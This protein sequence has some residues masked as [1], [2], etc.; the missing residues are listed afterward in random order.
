MSDTVS[1][2][3]L[4]REL[5][6]NLLRAYKTEEELW[7]QRS[8][9]LWLSLGDSNTAYFHAV[10]RGRRA[11]NKLSVIETESGVPVYEEEKIASVITQY[12]SE[13]FTS[14][15]FEGEH[16]V[17]KALTPCVTQEMNEKLIKEPSPE[18]VKEALLAIHADKAPGP[19]GFS[20]SFFHSNWD[21]VGPAIVL[22][23]QHFFSSGVLHASMNA[24]HTK[25]NRSKED[26]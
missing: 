12:Y 16:I 5:N 13:L 7:R 19:D 11:R 2:D 18:E 1:N 24:T 23:I 14:G 4:I 22:D 8:R 6:T 17:E 26:V 21:T 25:D 3:I 20:A 15:T 10:T 9:Q